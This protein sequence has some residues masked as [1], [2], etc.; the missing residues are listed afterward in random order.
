MIDIGTGPDSWGVWFPDEPGQISWQQY[1]TEA[2]EAGYT[3]TELGPYGYAPREPQRIASDLAGAGLRPLA[4]FAEVDL[5]SKEA[6]DD[7]VDAV[8]AVA[9]LVGAVGGRFVNVIDATYRDL[10]TGTPLGPAELDSA[11]WHQLTDLCN[12]LGALVRH[13]YDVTLTFHPH[14]DTHVERTEQIERFLEATDAEVVS[15]VL[16]TGHHAYRGG[17]P[18]GF[19]RDHN[20]RIGYLHVKSVDPDVRAAVDREDLPLV[21]AVKRGV[22]CE[23]AE[24]DVD[25][26][27]L[28]AAITDVGFTGPACVEQDMCHPAAGHPLAVATRT[29]AYLRGIGIG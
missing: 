12:R 17:D 7:V 29:R 11:A 15:L 6:E 3:F 26:A 1:V 28:A 5:S 22:F 14:V 25:F 8:D 9:Q 10:A 19:L 13:R 24:G 18:V 21:E 20:D 16:D 23:P 27:A 4:S 2:A